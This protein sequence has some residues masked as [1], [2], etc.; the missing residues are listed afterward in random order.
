MPMQAGRWIA[1]L[2]ALLCAC[3]TPDT[4]PARASEIVTLAR[5]VHLLPDRFDPG[6]QPDGNSLLLEGA[7]GIVV[8]DTGRHADHS[9]ALIEWARKRGQPIVAIVNSHWHLDHLG[10]NAALRR[11]H[12]GLQAY[13]SA[14]VNRALTTRLQRSEARLRARIEDPATDEATRRM[15]RVDL[16]LVTQ[17]DALM[18]DHT[19][20]GPPREISLGGRALRVGVET[21]VSGGDVWLLDRD[22]GI[23]AVGDFVTLPVPFLDTAC[24]PVWREALGRIESLPFQRLVPGH[25]PVMSRDDFRRYRRAFERL[26][27]CAGGSAPPSACAADWVADLGALLPAHAH[28]DAHEM[29]DGYF[30]Q[31][32]RAAP[33][34]R[35]LHCP[36]P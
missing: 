1:L 30:K 25:G 21:A 7:D 35:D 13:A 16:G 8:F 33:A 18:S 20:E 3:S 12:P 27:D 14:A 36:A 10:G 19:L 32:L 4:A 11:A 23:L 15:L 26:F 28:A 34:Q 31:N 17:R 6:R 2:C 9:A 29:I 22:S 24:A 5:G